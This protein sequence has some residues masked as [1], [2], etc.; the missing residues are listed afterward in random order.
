MI[1]E[2]KDGWS[3]SMANLDRLIAQ[4]DSV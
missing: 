2:F 1:A 4:Q 3:G